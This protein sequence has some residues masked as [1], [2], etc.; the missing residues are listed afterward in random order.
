[1][2]FNTTSVEKQSRPFGF[3]TASFF[4]LDPSFLVKA[5]LLERP[6][7]KGKAY[8]GVSRLDYASLL[9]K[10]HMYLH[11]EEEAIFTKFFSDRRKEQFLRGRY[12]A[13]KSLA[14]CL[15]STRP[16]EVAVKPG[17]FHQPLPTPSVAN[18]LGVSIAHTENRA[19]SLW[20]P[21]EHPMAIDVELLRRSNPNAIRSQ[22][23]DRECAL[24]QNTGECEMVFLT[25]VW[26]IKEGVCDVLLRGLWGGGDVDG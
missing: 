3:E 19:D 21:R 6:G 14:K 18:I 12:A 26:T 25:R 15:P 24:Q 5:I 22:L 16:T 17:I 11:T 1:M 9:M 20:F 4:N 8:W 13:K 2:L 23:T 7:W 10:K